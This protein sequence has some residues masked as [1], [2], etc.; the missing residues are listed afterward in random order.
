MR[1][2]KTKYR[3]NMTKIDAY[4]NFF[5]N[6]LMIFV[7]HGQDDTLE[8]RSA[9]VILQRVH[10]ILR[11][12]RTTSITQNLKFHYLNFKKLKIDNILMFF[13]LK[14]ITFLS[15]STIF[16]FSIFLVFY[17]LSNRDLQRPWSSRNASKP[18]GPRGATPDSPPKTKI[19]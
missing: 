11:E 12:G 13:W 9:S 7:Q 19:I 15:I 16:N 10:N 14:T 18:Q 8:V 17:F 2:N 5:S 6:K 1:T 4:Y 3:E